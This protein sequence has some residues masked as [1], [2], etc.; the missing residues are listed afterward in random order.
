VKAFALAFVRVLVQER[1]AGV[2]PVTDHEEIGE[3]QV[4][5]HE[6]TNGMG[7]E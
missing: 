6:P 1:V 2:G 5:Q 7:V 4:E 3:L